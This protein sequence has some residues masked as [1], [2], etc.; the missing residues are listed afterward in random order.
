V[1]FLQRTFTSLVHAHVG[2]TP[3]I[4]ADC[5]TWR[6]SSPS[7]QTLGQ[8]IDMCS[9][10]K[11]CRNYANFFEGGTKEQKEK[12]VSQEWLNT[13]GKINGYNEDTLSL[14]DDQ[15]PDCQ[16]LTNSGELCGI[17]VTE[18]VDRECIQLNERGKNVYRHWSN[19]EIIGAITERLRSKNVKTHGG[20]YK[21]LVVLIHTDEFEILFNEHNEVIE[22][23]TFRDIG[24]IDEAYLLYS[25]DP[26]HKKYP[27]SF[28]R[29]NSIRG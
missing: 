19:E 12:F 28:L 24:N 17:E 27:V 26:C 8:V 10:T 9:E 3:C 29:L 18:L 23:H 6:F 1:I 4:R 21:K 5:K 2:R 20:K 15:W 25:Y 14:V 13:Y 11:K 22:K 16:I 7:L